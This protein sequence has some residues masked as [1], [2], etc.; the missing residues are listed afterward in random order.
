MPKMKRDMNLARRIMIE[1]EKQETSQQISPSD[2]KGFTEEEV[3]YHVMLLDEAGLLVGINNSSANDTYWFADR[4]TWQGHEFL[5]AA[6]DNTR[7]EQAKKIVLEK[8]GGMAF[9][10]LKAVLVKLMTETVL[11]K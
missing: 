11:G 9:D 8:G 10:V 6:R 3:S 1:S 5:E 4:L 7:W 2:I